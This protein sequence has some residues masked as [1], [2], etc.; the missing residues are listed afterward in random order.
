MDNQPKF[1][2]PAEVV[3]RWNGAVTTGTLANW[4]SHGKGPKFQKFGSR[5]RY[6]LHLLEG[7]ERE[8]QVTPAASNDNGAGDGDTQAVA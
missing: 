5:V 1:L 7:W 6:P 8:N 4:R 2:T 3:K